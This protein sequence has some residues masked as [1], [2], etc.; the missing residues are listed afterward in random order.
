MNFNKIPET[1]IFTFL[2]V[3]SASIYLIASFFISFNIFIYFFSIGLASIFIFKKPKVGLYSIIILTFIFGFTFGLLPFEWND[4]IYKIYPIDIL[5]IITSLSFLFYKLRNPQEVKIKIGSKLGILIFVFL[6]YCLFSTIYGVSR[7]GEFSVAFSTL[8]NYAI[9][10]IFFFLTINIIDNKKKLKELIYTFLAGGIILIPFIFLGLFQGS[11]LFIEFTPLSTEGTRLLA[12]HQGFY[13]CVAILFAFNLIAFKKKVFG[14]FT[15]L[16]ILIEL[17]GVVGS[18]T[19][20]LWI[21]LFA[22]FILTFIFLPRNRKKNLLEIFAYQGLFFI[23]IIIVY[24][25]GSFLFTQEVKVFGLD[26]FNDATA[27]LQSLFNYSAQQDSSVYYR[28]LSWEKAFNEFSDSPIIGIGFGQKLSFDLL[29]W[30][31]IIEVRE[32]HNNFVGIILQMGILGFLTFLTFN[33]YFLIKSFALLKNSSQKYY[34]YI[35]GSI[36]CY[37]LYIISANFGTYFDTNI[38][39]IFY[40][41]FLGIIFILAEIK[42]DQTKE[43]S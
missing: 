22:C 39:N 17:V 8:K 27:R 24:A 31:I 28:I 38:F 5:T 32:L 35:L 10:S 29:G 41:I 34:P 2:S 6:L 33:I 36:S 42:H 4:D 30:P 37:F 7:G 12:P 25:L 13:L 15:T 14:K 9:Y 21:A 11:G 19:R 18:L 1:A 26:Y 40:W 16:I 23:I 3:A 43:I 20:H